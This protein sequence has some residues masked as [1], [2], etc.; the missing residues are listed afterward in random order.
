MDNVHGPIVEVCGPTPRG[1]RVGRQVIHLNGFNENVIITNIFPVPVL[2]KGEKLVYS[3]GV[4]KVA[5]ARQLPF[6]KGYVGALFASFIPFDIREE[7]LFEAARVVE[8]NGLMVLQGGRWDDSQ[9]AARVGL[10]N[11]EAWRQPRE[12]S[13]AEV[14]QF[15]FQRN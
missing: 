14:F 12:A 1:Y 10:Q 9:L 6:T 2:N 15:I 7:A 4:D 11:R 5:D 13:S 8:R 3:D